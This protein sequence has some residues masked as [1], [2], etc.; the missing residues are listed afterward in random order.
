MGNFRD[1]HC[2]LVVW[3]DHHSDDF[4]TVIFRVNHTTSF[5]AFRLWFFCP[6]VLAGNLPPGGLLESHAFGD[7]FLGPVPL[8][9]RAVLP[10]TV[11]CLFPGG[12]VILLLCVVFAVFQNYIMQRGRSPALRGMRTR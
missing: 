3:I 2:G 4:A 6:S 7:A 12:I 10:L 8:I 9:N 5:V 11:G 1:I